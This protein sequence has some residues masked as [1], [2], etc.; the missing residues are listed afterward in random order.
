MKIVNPKMISTAFVLIFTL[1][2]GT[3]AAIQTSETVLAD[4]AAD[5]LPAESKPA[6]KEA[7]TSQTNYF[8][9]E[10][11]FHRFIKRGKGHLALIGKRLSFV[12]AKY[13]E[14]PAELVKALGQLTGGRGPGY[15]VKIILLFLLLIASGIG[16]EK[17][18]NFGMIA[19]ASVVWLQRI[20]TL[21]NH[22]PRLQELK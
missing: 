8:V 2:L 19:P 20:K 17:F 9:E 4:D 3:A 21:P 14:I 10:S 7:L 1:M 5:K 12:F 15:L 11:A 16:A 13:A 6:S 18:F 22:S